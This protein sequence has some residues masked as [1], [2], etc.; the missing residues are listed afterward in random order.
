MIRLMSWFKKSTAYVTFSCWIF[1]EVFSVYL[2][3]CYLIGLIAREQPSSDTPVAVQQ[4]SQAPQ[5]S[6]WRCWTN[7]VSFSFWHLQAC[8]CSAGEWCEVLW[9][10]CRWDG[11]PQRKLFNKESGRECDCEKGRQRQRANLRSLILRIILFYNIFYSV[12]M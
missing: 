12:S 8:F 6:K 9:R 10:K 11:K 1:F 4:F 2:S 5:M 7:N 3:P